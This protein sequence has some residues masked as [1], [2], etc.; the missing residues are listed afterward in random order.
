VVEQIEHFEQPEHLYTV[1]DSNPFLKPRVHA[2]DRQ[3]HKAIAR[4]DRTVPP[5]PLQDDRISARFVANVGAEESPET[6]T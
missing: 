4:H 5:I 3:P 1:A 6:L 2:V